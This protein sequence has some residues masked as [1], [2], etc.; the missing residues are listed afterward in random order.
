MEDRLQDYHSRSLSNSK[1]NESI[2]QKQ[3]PIYTARNSNMPQLP[4][5]SRVYSKKGEYSVVTPENSEVQNRKIQELESTL[6]GYQKQFHQMKQKIRSQHGIIEAQKQY[7]SQIEG[8]L[9][10]TDKI[11]IENT[12]RHQ[13]TGEIATPT[14]TIDLFRANFYK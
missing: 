11:S 10:R 3:S 6:N 12:A 13:Y 4:N 9:L 2:F 14:E 5:S 7:I 8:I 1:M